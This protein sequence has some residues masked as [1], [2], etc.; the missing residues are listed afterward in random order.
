MYGSALE[1]PLPDRSVDVALACYAI[2]HMTGPTLTQNR[3]NLQRV[4]R[5]LGRVVKP[6]GEP[7]VFEISPWRSIWLAEKLLWNSARAVIGR[8]LDMC[9]YPVEVYARRSGDPTGRTPVNRDIQDATA[10]RVP[11]SLQPAL[12]Q[13]PA[14]PVPLRRQPLPVAPLVK[15]PPSALPSR[16]FVGG[17]LR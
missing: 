1:I 3:R 6:G 11:A 15:T 7:L 8:K 2:H 14:H 16:G 4:F 5:E 12:A 10:E 17:R 9:F 13:N